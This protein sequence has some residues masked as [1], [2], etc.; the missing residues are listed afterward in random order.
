[1]YLENFG[2]SWIVSRLIPRKIEALWH[3]HPGCK[4]GIKNKQIVSTQNERGNLEIIPVGSPHWTVTLVKGQQ[5]PQIQGWYGKEYDKFEPNK[6]IIYSTEIQKT[7][8]FVWILY[9]SENK[10]PSVQAQILSEDKDGFT[11]RVINHEEGKWILT[12]PFSEC[13]KESFQ[14][15][16]HRK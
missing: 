13:S 1:M 12:I 15:S 16:K 2:W 14:F 4:L 7:N 5:I 8:A 3:W 9:S 6:V 10:A 11:L